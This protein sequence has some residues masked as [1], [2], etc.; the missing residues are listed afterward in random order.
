MHKKYSVFQHGF[1][2]FEKFTNV[3]S[4]WPLLAHRDGMATSC[5]GPLSKLVPIG[6]AVL[7]KEKKYKTLTMTNAQVNNYFKYQTNA[8]TFSK[9]SRF[10][11]FIYESCCVYFVV[12]QLVKTT[13]IT[14]FLG[15]FVRARNFKKLGNF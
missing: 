3:Q 8:F 15:K 13:F 9:Q 6:W 5:C 10:L 1:W 11:V 14:N 4:V 2:N 7:Q 12:L